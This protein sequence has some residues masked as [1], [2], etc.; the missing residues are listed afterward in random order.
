MFKVTEVYLNTIFCASDGRFNVRVAPKFPKLP[1]L[2]NGALY[3]IPSMMII[4]CLV[5]LAETQE[6][7][8]HVPLTVRSVVSTVAWDGASVGKMRG[9]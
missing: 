8:V 4:S 1:N 2:R 5:I 7:N 6:I 9:S 3:C